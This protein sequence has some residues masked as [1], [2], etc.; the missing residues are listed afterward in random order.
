M[1]KE[2]VY[3]DIN[4]DITSVIDKIKQSSE[5]IVA[6]VPP[7][8]VGLLQSAVNLQLLARAAKS[9]RKYV[10]IITTK[11][12]LMK[13]AAL[14]KIPVAKTLQSKPVLVK[15]PDQS[16]EDEVIDGDNMPI[17]ELAKTAPATKV[18]TDDVIVDPTDPIKLDDQAKETPTKPAKKFHKV[19]LIALITGLV[20]TAGFLVWAIFFAPKAAITIATKTKT[21]N[22][23]KTVTLIEDSSK[24]NHEKNIIHSQVQRLEK[25]RSLEFEATGEKNVGEKATGTVRIKTDPLTILVYGLTV[26]TGTQIKSSG[27]LIFTT[28]RTGVIAKGDA[29]ALNGIDIPVTA[30]EGGEK[31]NGISGSATIGIGNVSSVTF[32]SATAG[33]TDKVVKVVT[34]QDLETAQTKLSQSDN[35]AVISELKNK[36]DASA[37]VVKESFVAEAGEAKSSVAVDNEAPEGKA[38][39]EQTVKYS[40]IALVRTRLVEYL[41]YVALLQETG[42]KIKQKVYETGENSVQ[43]SDF[44]NKEGVVSVKVF[45]HLRVGPEVDVEEVRQFAKGKSYGEIQ[46]QYEKIEGIERVTVDFW[47]M[48][49]RRV[50]DNADKITVKISLE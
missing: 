12:A 7:K 39:L 35:E 10:V 44:S 41:N 30:I 50:P 34:K 16:I 46:D 32:T 22:I 18:K 11:E 5:K 38:K 26:P 47:P 48:W 42:T 4:D 1:S 2:V 19:K 20:G 36:F 15:L 37:I 25:T 40:M 33:G 3:I 29:T 27:G 13:L 17:G 31:Y 21:I 43:F 28:N 24:V 14:A 9:V 45:A 8:Q 49:V 23:D 6:L